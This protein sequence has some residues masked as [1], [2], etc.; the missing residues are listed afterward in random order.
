LLRTLTRPVVATDLDLPVLM[1][2]RRYL[3]FWGLY[4]RASLLA[5]DVRRMPFTDGAVSTLTTFVGLP[6]VQEPG[7]LLSELRRIVSGQFVAITLFY[8][9]EDEVHAPAIRS[10]GLELLLFRD[11]ALEAFAAAGWHVE[12]IDDCVARVLPTPEGVL[13]EGFQVDGLPL[14]ETV[15]ELC[16]LVAH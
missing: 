7:D 8:S 11:A 6:N 14:A 16:V 13:L 9:P 5:L 2:D 3:E 1:R 10:A 12:I 15:Q 4:D